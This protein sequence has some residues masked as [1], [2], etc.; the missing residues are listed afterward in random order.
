MKGTDIPIGFPLLPNVEE[1]PTHPHT[2]IH[3]YIHTY[4]AIRH[5]QQSKYGGGVYANVRASTVTQSRGGHVTV[6]AKGGYG[7]M[8]AI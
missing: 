3:T 7:S 5:L 4:C 1:R 6:T 8:L 2:Y